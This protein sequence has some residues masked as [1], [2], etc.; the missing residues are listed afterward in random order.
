MTE[1]VHCSFQLFQHA[2]AGRE[3]LGDQAGPAGEQE[4][5][6]ARLAGW[7]R[8]WQSSRY[9][10]EDL[11]SAKVVCCLERLEVSLPGQGGIEALQ[12]LGRREQQRHRLAAAVPV[13]RGP[14]AQPLRAGSLEFADGSCL[15]GREKL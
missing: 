2:G 10:Q 14:G 11:R 15:G 9:F 4:L 13:K 12:T 6:S 1:C 8:R 3:A 7:G 5:Q